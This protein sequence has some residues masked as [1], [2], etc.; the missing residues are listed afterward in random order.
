MGR[1]EGVRVFSG[2]GARAGVG[3][4]IDHLLYPRVLHVYVCSRSRVVDDYVF[5]KDSTIS[6]H[7]M[8]EGFSRRFLARDC[9]RASLCRICGGQWH[10]Y[11]LFSKCLGF[12]LSV[13]FLQCSILIF[14]QSS[15]D[16]YS[17]REQ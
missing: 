4:Y 1:R 2:F 10:W 16:L 7:A 17:L 8:A 12:T 5:N 13:S 6:G 3:G 9:F 11:R 15:A 14:R